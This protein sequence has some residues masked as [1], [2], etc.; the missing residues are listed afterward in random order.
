LNNIPYA[1]LAFIFF[2]YAA[3]TS[4]L[5]NIGF[6][7]LVLLA[8]PSLIKDQA[9]GRYICP[10]AI[11][12]ITWLLLM[13]FGL[14]TGVVDLLFDGRGLKTNPNSLWFI[15]WLPLAQVYWQPKSSRILYV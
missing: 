7:L 1:L 10:F 4:K 2:M 3:P 9:F 5:A 8:A 14:L 15:F 11:I 6:Y 13:G 12:I